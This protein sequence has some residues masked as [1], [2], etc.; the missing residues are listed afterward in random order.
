MSRCLSTLMVGIAATIAAGCGGSSSSVPPQGTTVAVTFSG[1]NTPSAVATQSGNGP[2]AAASLQG[3]NQLFLTLPNGTVKYGIA[4]VC[5]AFNDEFVFE[6][7]TQD[8][9]ALTL[10]CPA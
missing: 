4:Y 5:S 3:G 6:A 1:T 9:T 8:A 7:T 10:S 2:F